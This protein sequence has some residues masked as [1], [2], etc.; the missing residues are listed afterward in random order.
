MKRLILPCLCIFCLIDISCFSEENEAEA[1]KTIEKTTI[2]LS[3][4]II[5]YSNVSIHQ[6]ALY[7]TRTMTRVD[8]LNKMKEIRTELYRLPLR[9]IDFKNCSYNEI[10]EIDDVGNNIDFA[11]LSI[12]KKDNPSYFESYRSTELRDEN[13]KIIEQTKD[14][15]ESVS[16]LYDWTD[17]KNKPVKK[18]KCGGMLGS[19]CTLYF[20]TLDDAL[21]WLSQLGHIVNSHIYIDYVQKVIETDI[22]VFG[23]INMTGHRT[24]KIAT[25]IEILD[26]I[27]GA[28]LI[29]K[30]RLWVQYKIP[31]NL[32]FHQNN[33]KEKF[34]FLLKYPYKDDAIGLFCEVNDDMLSNINTIIPITSPEIEELK[35]KIGP[36]ERLPYYIY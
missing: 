6:D 8:N 22:V 30:R 10:K 26:I 28:K 12:K 18:S 17:S 32:Y 3:D 15:S 24:G 21:N 9:N 36:V 5:Q 13:G 34:I 14:S 33:D 4:G 11:R 7:L 19:E 1:L 27:K 31:D 20:K 35:K 2:K 29:D 23:K 25:E 16:W